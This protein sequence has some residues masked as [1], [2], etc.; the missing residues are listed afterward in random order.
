MTCYQ[1][2]GALRGIELAEHFIKKPP[3]FEPKSHLKVPFTVQNKTQKMI[4]LVPLIFILPV[5]LK[6]GLMSVLMAEP[7]S[8]VTAGV[9]TG[10]LFFRFYKKEFC[11]EIAA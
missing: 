1:N 10:T 6:G 5:V 3:Y 2:S 4:L 7:I 9:I 8:D 11:N